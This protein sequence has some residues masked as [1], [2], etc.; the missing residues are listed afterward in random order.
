MSQPPLQNRV[1]IVDD[2]VILRDVLSMLLGAEGY[3]VL[4][5][6]SGEEALRLLESERET[7][8][9]ILTD[10]HM[11]G[12]HGAALAEKLK[13]AMTP[14]TVIVGMS[15]SM[16]TA[17]EKAIFRSFLEKP[18]TAGAFSAA[19]KRAA[20]EE[21]PRTEPQN[22]APH[23]QVLNGEVYSRLAAIMPAPQLGELYRMTLDDVRRRV[24]LM[25][26]ALEHGDVATCR[27]EAH[28]IKGG[29]GM[30]GAAEL[31]TMAAEI[32]HAAEPDLATLTNFDAACV[33]LEDMLDAHAGST[34]TTADGE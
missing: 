13:D 8:S 19:V 23:A 32:E 3:D 16:P 12:I 28:A 11:P 31:G 14:G 4:L 30:V 6:E 29:C 15:G 21:L 7:I 33:R 5:A 2:D 10:M 17:E 34:S 25:Q 1:L 20:S 22:A 26:K 24:G 27:A 9:V 18:F